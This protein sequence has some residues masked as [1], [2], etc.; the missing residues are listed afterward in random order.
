MALLPALEP[1]ERVFL[2]LGAADLDHRQLGLGGLHP[3]RLACLLPIVWRPRRVA[4]ALLLEQL[5]QRLERARLRIDPRMPIAQSLEPCGH[6]RQREI[7]RLAVGDFG[8]VERCRHRG[9]RRRAHRVGRCDG[10][11]LGVLVVV[12][13]HAVAL[14]LPPLARRELRR[15]T[16]DV[17]G[18]RER[19]AAHLIERPALRDAHI[20][21]HASLTRCL[22][23]ADEANVFQRRLGD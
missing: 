5:E 11:V 13:E 21:V 18:E 1:G 17:A 12:D 6:R 16:L 23:P 22:R 15:A 3:R 19:R 2:A 10:A 4:F 8:P 14:L 9:F 20:D 7:A